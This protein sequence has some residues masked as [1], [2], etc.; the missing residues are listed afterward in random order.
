MFQPSSSQAGVTPPR[1][2]SFQP[3]S[4]QEVVSHV[5]TK[6]R[7][8][9]SSMMNTQELNG[10]W[11]D[12]SVHKCFMG[13]FSKLKIKGMMLKKDLLVLGAGEIMH[14]QLAFMQR[15]ILKQG[16]MGLF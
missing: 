3:F 8:A 5:K 9:L 2:S 16:G 13:V 1:V 7:A 11:R 14:Q 6:I 15:L 12:I 10:K 4:L